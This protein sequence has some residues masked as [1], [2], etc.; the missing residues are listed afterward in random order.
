[1]PSE[2]LPCPFCGSIDISIKIVEV[3]IDKFD[4]VSDAHAVCG[5]CKATGPPD[6]AKYESKWGAVTKAWN[7]RSVNPL[8]DIIDRAKKEIDYMDSRTSPNVMLIRIHR[9]LDILAESNPKD[10]Q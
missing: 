3:S 6:E 8:L 10:T 4:G 2:L 9:V 1:M 7:T 5:K